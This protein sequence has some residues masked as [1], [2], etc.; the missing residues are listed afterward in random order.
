M[1]KELKIKHL[2]NIKEKVDRMIPNHRNIEELSKLINNELF[3]EENLEKPNMVYVRNLKQ[4]IN[5]QLDSLV[6][7]RKNLGNRIKELNECRSHFKQDI[8]RYLSDLR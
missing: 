6:K 1:D 8:D 2:E 3:E 7:S 4:T 5:K